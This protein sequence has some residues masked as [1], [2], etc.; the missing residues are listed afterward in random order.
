MPECT[1]WRARVC[2]CVRMSMCI[3]CQWILHSIIFQHYMCYDW[4]FF[5]FAHLHTH[6]RAR[7][8]ILNE[9]HQCIDIFNTFILI[10]RSAM[11]L[12]HANIII[13]FVIITNLFVNKII[14]KKR[15]K[16]NW[17]TKA[18]RTT[19]PICFS[20]VCVFVLVLMFVSLCTRAT[21][22]LKQF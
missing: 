11:D 18:G 1:Y 10:T 7:T 16:T 17:A 19:H 5:Y 8:P 2:A 3:E 13:L 15:L 22:W 21:S 12:H 4:T 9:F 20:C 14:V 6:T